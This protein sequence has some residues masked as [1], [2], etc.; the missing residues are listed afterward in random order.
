[1]K[2]AYFVLDTMDEKGKYYTVVCPISIEHD[3]VLYKVGQWSG[4]NKII[5]CMLA[6]TKKKAFEICE[7]WRETHIQ[8]NEY[9]D[10]TI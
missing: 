4:K 7:T 2:K 8:N 10:L 1:M 5:T 6:S 3:D 9:I